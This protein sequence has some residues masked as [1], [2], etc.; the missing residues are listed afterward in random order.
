MLTKAGDDDNDED[1]VLPSADAGALIAQAAVAA[2]AEGDN[3]FRVV[4]IGK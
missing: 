4:M 1:E 3:K 2:I